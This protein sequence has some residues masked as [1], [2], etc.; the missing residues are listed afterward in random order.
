[1][2]ELDD[3]ATAIPHLL[4]RGKAR[5]IHQDLGQQQPFRLAGHRAGPRHQPSQ[6]VLRQLLGV[7]LLLFVDPHRRGAHRGRA[8][9]DARV[10]RNLGRVGL[11]VV[12]DVAIE[13]ARLVLLPLGPVE[14]VADRGLGGPLLEEPASNGFRDSAKQGHGRSYSQ[15][16]GLDAWASLAMA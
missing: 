16:C 11:A 14:V 10:D 4:D 5:G 13:P 2:P 15:I 8:G 6:R 7:A 9:H 1:M 12:A 3:V